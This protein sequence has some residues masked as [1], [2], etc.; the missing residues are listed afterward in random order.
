MVV[1]KKSPDPTDFTE[2]LC[3]TY[4]ATPTFPVLKTN[5]FQIYLNDNSIVFVCPLFTTKYIT[6]MSFTVRI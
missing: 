6:D 3:Q 5:V 2:A 1:L 4:I